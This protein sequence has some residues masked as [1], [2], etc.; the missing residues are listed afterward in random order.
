MMSDNESPPRTSVSI[1]ELIQIRVLLGNEEQEPSSKTT[2][3][4][5]ALD[6]VLLDFATSLTKGN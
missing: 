6:S 4:L 3:I 2:A 1:Q 5:E